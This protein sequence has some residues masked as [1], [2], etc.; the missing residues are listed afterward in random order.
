MKVEGYYEMI[1][2]NPSQ[3][4]LIIDLATNDIDVTYSELIVFI[5]NPHQ[6]PLKGGIEV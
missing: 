6:Y 3:I 2:E 4:A 1:K 5:N